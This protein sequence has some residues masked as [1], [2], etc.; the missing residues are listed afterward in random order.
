[1]S[2]SA[3]DLWKCLL[4]YR[5]LSYVFKRCTRK[6]L[7]I[8]GDHAEVSWSSLHGCAA[9]GKDTKLA[10]FSWQISNQKKEGSLRSG[11]SQPSPI[12]LQMGTLGFRTPKLHITHILY[13]LSDPGSLLPVVHCA[14]PYCLCLTI[15]IKILK[16]SWFSCFFLHSTLPGYLFV[17]KEP[18]SISV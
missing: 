11:Q 2:W 18:D 5:L 14:W 15:R 4:Y 3:R 8:H 12:I 16:S 7:P 17:I 6:W 9:Y 10:M 1:M 13:F